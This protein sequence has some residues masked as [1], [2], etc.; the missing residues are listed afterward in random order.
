MVE[1]GPD[2]VVQNSTTRTPASGK[3]AAAG[4]FAVE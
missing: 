4:S 2:A 1:K 3:T